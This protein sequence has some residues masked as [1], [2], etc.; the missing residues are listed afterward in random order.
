MKQFW[1]CLEIFI[2]TP[3]INHHHFNFH[4]PLIYSHLATKNLFASSSIRFWFDHL[5][6]EKLKVEVK[7]K[8]ELA[9][10]LEFLGGPLIQT[11][12]KSGVLLILF[13]FH[14]VCIPSS[15]NMITCPCSFAIPWIHVNMIECLLLVCYSW[16]W[17]C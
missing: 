12:E 2:Q 15:L 6:E 14:H 9:I 17:V 5:E 7:S 16:E 13:A 4:Y 3:K 10:L 8:K 1:P 11:V